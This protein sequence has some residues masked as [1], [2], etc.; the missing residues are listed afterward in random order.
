MIHQESVPQLDFL[1]SSKKEKSWKLTDHSW[2]PSQYRQA[3]VDEKVCTTS[4]L[5]EDG[6]WRKQEGKEIQKYIRLFH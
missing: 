5:E 3:N 2:N 4:S 6:D 1:L